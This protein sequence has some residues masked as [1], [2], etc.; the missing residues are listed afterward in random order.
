[1]SFGIENEKNDV[2]TTITTKHKQQQQMKW[3]VNMNKHGN[4]NT[5]IATHVWCVVAA[6]QSR[7]S[8]FC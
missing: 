2:L 3:K 6:L 5:D 8:E 4:T 7:F 1:M